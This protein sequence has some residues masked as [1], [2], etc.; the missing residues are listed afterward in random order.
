MKRD[1]CEKGRQGFSTAV[2]VSLILA[3]CML[4][5]VALPRSWRCSS[6]AGG[7]DGR[8][9]YHEARIVVVAAVVVVVVTSVARRFRRL[10]VTARLSVCARLFD[11][12]GIQL[13]GGFTRVSERGRS[14]DAATNVCNS[15]NKRETASF[16][17]F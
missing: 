17:A 16:C 2:F 14:V 7:R 5:L 4:M 3:A 1:N 8:C 6:A 10:S 13:R 9:R 12:A 15:S 11:G